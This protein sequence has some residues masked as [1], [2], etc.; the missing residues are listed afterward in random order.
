MKV[1]LNL[2][3]NEENEARAN[4]NENLPS[5]EVSIDIGQVLTANQVLLRNMAKKIEGLETKLNTIERAAIERLSVEKQM[6][7]Y[8]N[9]PT[10]KLVEPWSP[11]KTKKP[12]KEKLTLTDRLFRPWLLR[13]E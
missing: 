2:N 11:P 7:T 12:V 13:R 8:L 1:E 6:I 3:K 5:C 9:M 4:Q 10:K